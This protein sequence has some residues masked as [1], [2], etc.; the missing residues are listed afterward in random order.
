MKVLNYAPGPMDTE[1][2]K[3]I[4]EQV[5]G[6]DRNI[7]VDIQES[8]HRCVRLAIGGAFTTG[9]HIDFYDQEA[10]DCSSSRHGA[11]SQDG[12]PTTDS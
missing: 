3:P 9:A 10:V 1:M 4:R 11:V 8:A 5:L 12:L 7:M 2:T 6:F